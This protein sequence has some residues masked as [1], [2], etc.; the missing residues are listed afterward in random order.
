ME[1]DGSLLNL[2]QRELTDEFSFQAEGGGTRARGV[3]KRASGG[4]YKLGH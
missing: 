2:L 1:I 3:A 4:R